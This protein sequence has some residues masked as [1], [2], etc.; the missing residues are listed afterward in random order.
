MSF[1]TVVFEHALSPFFLKPTQA[2]SADLVLNGSPMHASWRR[3]VESSFNNVVR[4][5]FDRS[6]FGTPYWPMLSQ[7]ERLVIL[8]VP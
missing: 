6:R 3:T 5:G 2:R 4:F 7:G 8:R 1:K